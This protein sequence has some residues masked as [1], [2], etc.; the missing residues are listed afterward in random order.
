MIRNV[1]P[2]T[3]KVQKIFNRTHSHLSSFNDTK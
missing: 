2:K 3:D 1:L